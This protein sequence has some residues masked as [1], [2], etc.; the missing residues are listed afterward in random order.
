MDDREIKRIREATRVL[1]EQS[2]TLKESVAE[3]IVRS[4][5][6]IG[7]LKA[8]LSRMKAQRGEIWSEIASSGFSSRGIDEDLGGRKP[9]SELASARVVR[10]RPARHEGD[11]SRLITC[12]IAS[13][14]IG[15]ATRPR[16]GPAGQ[17]RSLLSSRL[18]LRQ[19]MVPRPVTK[20]MCPPWLTGLYGSPLDS[21]CRSDDKPARPT[22]PPCRWP[23]F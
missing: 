14:R 6:A 10:P 12:R 17:S 18:S 15:L 22:L 8:I 7:Q 21:I 20:P 23:G 2:R 4:K 13:W 16:S 9:S 1:V 11:G 3:T 5:L 19:T